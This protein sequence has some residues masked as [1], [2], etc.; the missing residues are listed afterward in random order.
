M[1]YTATVDFSNL[2]IL[3][4]LI[5][6]YFRTRSGHRYQEYKL[7]NTVELNNMRWNYFHRWRIKPKISKWFEHDKLLYHCYSVIIVNTTKW[8]QL[9]GLGYTILSHMYRKP[10]MTQIHIRDSCNKF[11]VTVI[12]VWWF[13]VLVY[14]VTENWYWRVQQFSN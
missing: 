3:W 6:I 13:E 14:K 9:R 5:N 10:I 8:K 7:R 11:M 2:V 12:S 1:K 4:P